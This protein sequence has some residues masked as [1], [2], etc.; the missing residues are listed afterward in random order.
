MLP[1]GRRCRRRP[2]NLRR[3]GSD[4][5]ASAS[6]HRPSTSIRINSPSVRGSCSRTGT[7]RVAAVERGQHRRQRVEAEPVVGGDVEPAGGQL[8]H[9]ADRRLGRGQ[10]P[11]HP[12]GR[13]DQGQ[14]GRGRGEPAPVADEQLG[15]QVA[16]ERPDRLG[17]RGLRHVQLV[18][19]HGDPPVLDHG[20]EVLQPAQV[21]PSPGPAARSPAGPPARLS[22]TAPPRGPRTPGPPRTSGRGR[23]TSPYGRTIGGSTGRTTTPSAAGRRGRGVDHER[24]P[25]PGPHQLQ[26][27]CRAGRARAPAGS[28]RRPPRRAAS[29]RSRCQLPARR[30]DQPRPRP[31]GAAAPAP[32]SHLGPD[33]A[34]NASISSCRPSSTSASPSR[35]TGR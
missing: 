32:A 2:V 30:A 1:L 28:A 16:L 20:Q 31:A 34:G 10:V 4:W 6:S 35:A 12:A 9:V 29:T 23:C 19:G 25:D 22:R 14:P 13:L 8:D 26:A 5:Y 7:P 21:H 33:A 18:R 3:F 15:A 11:Q 24:G 27:W 17:Q